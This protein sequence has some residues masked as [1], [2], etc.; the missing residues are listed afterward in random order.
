M[1]L[2]L[3]ARHFTIPAPV[4]KLAEERLGR[5]LRPLN[6]SAVSAQVV[7]TR[8]K[9]RFHAEVTLHAGGEHFLPGEAA[10]R[11]A[12]PALGASIDKVE[13][14]VLKLK[15]KWTER[16]RQGISPAKAASATP[17]PGRGAAVFGTGLEQRDNG[18]QPPRIIPARRHPGE[19]MSGDEAAVE[20]AGGRHALLLFP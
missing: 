17:R 5:V 12:Q 13:R 16:K 1:R 3:T 11:D 15:S 7:V 8:D 14:Q 18:G 19:P 20:G 2:E 6:D 4:R 10:G 9:T